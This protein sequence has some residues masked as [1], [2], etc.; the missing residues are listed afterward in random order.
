MVT[1]PERLE[2]SVGGWYCW[3]ALD[4][5]VDELLEELLEELALDELVDE[6]SLVEVL[7]LSVEDGLV[8][9]DEV[10]AAAGVTIEDLPAYEV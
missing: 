2:P 10:V 4:E 8:P 3:V 9:D 7:L 1:A 5:L 6:P